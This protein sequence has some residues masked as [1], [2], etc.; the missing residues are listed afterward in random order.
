MG[1]L[2]RV[3]CTFLIVS[4]LLHPSM[5]FALASTIKLDAA[6]VEE[7]LDI[8]IGE[9]RDEFNIPN[10]TVS[11]VSGGEII[12]AKGYGYADYENNN[13]VD[14]EK[15]LF[16][17]GS[18]SKLFTWTAVMQLVEAGKLDLDT[19]INEYLDFELPDTIEYKRGKSIAEPITIKH[20]MSHSPG[21]EDYMTNVFSLYEDSLIPLAQYVR[22][23][24]PTRVFV[25]GEV[26]A[27]S[28]YGTAL[29][30]YIVEV[31]SGVPFAQYVE[32]NIYQPLG[33][34]FSTFRQPLPSELADHMSKSYRSVNGEFVEAKFEFVPEPAGSMS[35]SAID[36]AK[37][38][39]AYLQKGQYEGVS[40]LKE[41]TVQKMFTEQF[42]QHPRL[43]GMAYG[44]IK[45]TFNGRDIFHHPGGM[46]LY[47]T[48]FYLIP[49]EE[50]GF[51]IS[52]SGGNY[53][54]NL[55][56][57]QEFMNRYFPSEAEEI[58]A[59]VPTANMDQRSSEY[60]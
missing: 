1:R 25:P 45:A 36:M 28:N 26:T 43:D 4:F 8:V 56:I 35:S 42:S 19:D 55:E 39:L 15:T 49:D 24:R 53:L 3:L 60:V 48:S 57:F 54:V 27:Y 32:E 9:R 14:P 11:V 13:L 12:F 29:A 41:D 51:F 44:F 38:M 21:F 46:M 5:N 18:T 34:E 37:F 47:D 2:R 50:V 33:M 7:F 22:E 6:D 30:G 20:L 59:P 16:R 10:V 58:V 40:I 17:I 23:K 52:H 31:V